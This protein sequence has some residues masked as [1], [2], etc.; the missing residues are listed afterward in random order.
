[1]I[2]RR[3][4]APAHGVRE[5]PPQLA[6]QPL[7][8]GAAARAGQGR[9][10]TATRSARAL[11]DALEK[12]TLARRGCGGAAV[13]T[14]AWPAFTARPTRSTSSAVSWRV[15]ALWKKLQQR[16]HLLAVIG[17]SGAGKSS[18]LRAGLLPAMP[19]RAGGRVCHPGDAPIMAALAQTLVD[20]FAGDT[21]AMRRTGRG[22]TIP[23]IAVATFAR[24]RK[25]HREALLI[26]DQFEELFTLNPPETPR[27]FAEVL[28]RLAL[29][30]NVHVLL[31]MR[32]DFLFHCSRTRCWRPIFSELTPLRHP[33]AG[34]ALRRAS[35]SRRCLCGYRFEDDAL[36]EEM[37]RERCA[38]SGGRFRCW[39]SAWPGCG[40]IAT[41]AGG[42]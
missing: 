25:R 37:T 4:T 28:G 38:G 23:D 18:F 26:V 11:S 35:S 5:D 30:P 21:E 36:V 20:E 12:M 2:E 1:M 13:P 22:S 31:S 19:A 3:A 27:R 34:A 6:R 9:R 32:D 17:P 14:P 40:S 39:R 33:P 7:A 10:P 29:E 16:P 42:C 8:S 41:G 24:W 15:E